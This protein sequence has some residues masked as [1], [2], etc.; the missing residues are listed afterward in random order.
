MQHYI[1]Y[2]YGFASEILTEDEF[3]RILD[4]NDK[5]TNK[6]I[7]IRCTPY[8]DG[9]YEK[10]WCTITLLSIKEIQHYGKMIT[11]SEIEEIKKKYGIIDNELKEKFLNLLKEHE[12]E[13]YI[14][15]VE[16]VF[17]SYNC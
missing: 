8:T 5:Y 4:I 7:S 2:G 11:L 15:N 9:D 3:S 16:L 1:M 13:K 17:Y 12:L 6:N 14:D 10:D